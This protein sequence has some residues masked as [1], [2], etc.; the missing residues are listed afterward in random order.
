MLIS[1]SNI[2]RITEAEYLRCTCKTEKRA[3]I[4]KYSA[5]TVCTVTVQIRPG[6]DVPPTHS[7][8]HDGAVFSDQAISTGALTS[9]TL[10]NEIS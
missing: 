1:I 9:H 3:Y 7:G 2:H 5:G 6:P 4:Y 10:S 8:L